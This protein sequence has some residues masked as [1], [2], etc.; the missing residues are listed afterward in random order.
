VKRGEEQVAIDIGNVVRDVEDAA[1]I[2]ALG[3]HD[4]GN[5][6]RCRVCGERQGADRDKDS[7]NCRDSG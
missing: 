6:R 1:S 2:D 3:Q 5:H 4:I 7:R